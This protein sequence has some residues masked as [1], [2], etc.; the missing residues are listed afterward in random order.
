MSEGAGGVKHELRVLQGLHAGAALPLE[1]GAITVGADDDCDVVL[2]DDGVLPVHLRLA[3]IGG[4]WIVGDEGTEVALGVRIPVGT[5]SI[6]LCDA[7]EPWS[8]A[9]PPVPAAQSDTRSSVQASTPKRTAPRRIAIASLAGAALLVGLALALSNMAAPSKAVVEPRPVAAA[10]PPRT[11]ALA[12]AADLEQLTQEILASRDLREY[13]SVQ[14]QAGQ[15]LL[16]AELDD[17]QVPRFEGALQ[18][19]KRRIGD[20]AHLQ[21]TLVPLVQTL[22]FQIREIVMGPVSYITTADGRRLSEG[23]SA[24]GVRLVAIRPGKLVF[25]GRHRVEIAW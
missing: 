15:I 16:K 19:L 14:T 5:A 1:G 8:N 20:R 13:V 4:R 25:A 7:S 6:M 10:Q 9:P 12:S 21:A 3:W 2:L 11:G 17:D 23:A 24:M 18:A 22:P